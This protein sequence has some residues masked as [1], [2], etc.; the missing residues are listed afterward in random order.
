MLLY[1]SNVGYNQPG[2]SYSGSLTISAPRI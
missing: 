1:N 2:V